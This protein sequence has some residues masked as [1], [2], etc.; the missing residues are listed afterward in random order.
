MPTSRVSGVTALLFVLLPTAA[1][2]QEAS[3]SDAIS[4]ANADLAPVGVVDPNA[5]PTAASVPSPAPTVSTSPSMPATSAA[6]GG[7]AAALP[8]TNT[9]TY[10][11]KDVLTEAE[12]VFGRGAEGL[13][14]MIEGLFKENGEPNGY[15]VGREAGG[16][17][18]VG[19]RYGSG[20]LFHRVEGQQPIYWTGPSVG[21]DLGADAS[22]TFTLVYNLH[23]TQDVFHRFPA[24]EGKVYVIGG[25]TATYLQRNDVMLVPIKLGVGWRLGANVGYLNFTKSSRILPF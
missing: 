13:A 8:A 10:A 15:I 22:K 23:D 3:S 18:A 9:T 7:T 25:F 11:Q 17:I 6:S 24:V 2:A 5:L 4:A 20:T 21:F 19:L 12:N 14:K 16:A 1:M